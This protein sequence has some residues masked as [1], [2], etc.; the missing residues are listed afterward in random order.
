[1]KVLA[2]KKQPRWGAANVVDDLD[3]FVTSWNMHGCKV[4]SDIRMRE[5][6]P[7]DFDVYVVA[8][9]ECKGKYLPEWQRMIAV[10]LNGVGESSTKHQKLLGLGDPYSCLCAS[11]MWAIHVLI[12]VRTSLLP[13]FSQLRSETKRTGLGNV[14]GNKGAV[15]VSFV[16]GDGTAAHTTSFAFVNR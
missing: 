12:F 8:L 11:S 16:Y 7:D 5:W 3:M 9:Q 6:L 10:H 15:G 1:M 4:P 2:Q 14:L 13:L